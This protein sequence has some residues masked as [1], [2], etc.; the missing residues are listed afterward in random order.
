MIPRKSKRFNSKSYNSNKNESKKEIIPNHSNVPVNISRTRF[1]IIEECCSE[2]QFR[3]VE[4]NSKAL[5]FWCDAGGSFEFISSLSQF[6]FCNHFPGTWSLARKVDLSRNIGRLA[7][8]LPQIYDFHPK[9]FII[10]SQY[11]ELEMYMKEKQKENSISAKKKTKINNASS[12]VNTSTFD[13]EVKNATI[14]EN[15]NDDL[16]KPEQKVTFIIKPDKGSFGRG[17]ILIQDPS[18]IS[19]Y[20]NTAIAQQY[21]EP[22]LIDGL[23]FDLRIYALVVSI[24]PL[25]IYLHKEGLARFCTEKYEKPSEGNLELSFAHLTNYA[26]NKN[27][28]N[29]QQPKDDNGF[30]NSCHKRSMNVVLKQIERE[31]KSK[32]EDPNCSIKQKSNSKQN[33]SSSSKESSDAYDFYND[34]ELIKG[35]EDIIRLTVISVQPYIASCYKTA[36]PV[37]DGKSRCFEI[38]GFDIMIDDE[39]KPWLLEVNWSPSFA[40]ESPFDV[41]LKK[42]VIKGALK[43]VNV[44]SNFKK[45]VVARRKAIASRRPSQ[46]LWSMDEE[47]EIAKKTNYK[48][49]YPLSPG[50]DKYTETEMAFFESKNAYQPLN[51]NVKSVANSNNISVNESRKIKS[52]NTFNLSDNSNQKSVRFGNQESPRQSFSQRGDYNYP[53]ICQKP[54]QAKI[55]PSV[56]R[57]NP[58]ATPRQQHHVMNIKNS[59][60]IS[61]PLFPVQPNIEDKNDSSLSPVSNLRS[62]VTPFYP[63]QYQQGRVKSPRRISILT[64]KSE[65]NEIPHIAPPS[66]S[67]QTIQQNDAMPSSNSDSSSA[68]NRKDCASIKENGQIASCLTS[69]PSK[70][71]IPLVSKPSIQQQTILKPR[72]TIIY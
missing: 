44:P 51:S 47:L 38:L 49:I 54:I 36:I 5:I 60:S 45:C 22:Y 7:K 43:I 58:T 34:S 69:N 32:R 25:R 13:N 9:S 61:Q 17:I 30:D 66:L 70:L 48:L 18:E 14:E 56:A 65:P 68:S 40:D 31:L 21:I 29:F 2:L 4:S 35:I 46:P 3:V 11:S 53:P 16:S 52:Y 67:P 62:E 71:T 33:E 1:P 24:D 57:P 19:G 12:K 63:K 10:P 59:K 28:P 39:G 37:D 72:Q 27:N 42:S 8:V 64:S 26:L 15:Q 50:D 23:K 20:Y 41:S 55:L 6:Q